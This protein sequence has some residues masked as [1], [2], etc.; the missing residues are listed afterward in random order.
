MLYTIYYAILGW[1]IPYSTPRIHCRKT[2]N[3]TNWGIPLFFSFLLTIILRGIAY[4]TG[5]DYY[6]YHDYYVNT[7]KNI[8]D[9]WGE[10]TEIGYKYLI[11]I[12]TSISNHPSTFFILSSFILLYSVISLSTYYGNARKYILFLWPVFLHCIS[13]NLYR[14]FW[15][16]SFIYLAFLH[17]NKNEIKKGICF[18]LLTICFHT[19]SIIFLMILLLIYKFRNLNINKWLLIVLV[20][21]T[22]IFNQQIVN[23]MLWGANLISIYYFLLTGQ[24]YSES[25]SETLYDSSILLIPN[26]ITYIIWIY[27][28]DKL[29]Q[30]EPSYKILYYIVTIGLIIF[31]ITRQEVFLRICLYFMNF[32]PIFIGILLSRN[33]NFNKHPLLWVSV[34]YYILLYF[35]NIYTL[36][37]DFPLTFINFP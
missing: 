36:G 30:K 31:P 3:I 6:H 21:I 32:F 15:A 22:S 35:R 28:G 16:M 20:T 8:D 33:K 17:F 7:S 2:K 37:K 1:L 19:S 4:E 18:I 12:L 27:Y 25:L 13:F 34:I 14:Q 11:A 5:V 24:L 26:L 10:H 9:P 23:L 29:C